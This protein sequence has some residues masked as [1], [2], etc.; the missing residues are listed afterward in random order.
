MPALAAEAFDPSG[1]DAL[2]AADIVI[3]GEHH[4][5]PHHHARQAELI[6]RVQPKAVVW[7]MLT[8]PDALLIT[9]DLIADKAALRAALEWD[10][11]GWPDFDLY[12]PVFHAARDAQHFGAEIPR[13]ALMD[14]YREGASA[15]LPSA[16]RFRLAEPLPESE[17]R[18]REAMQKA[19][20]CDML[21]DDQL[22]AMVEVQRARDASLADASLRALETT[23]G[24]VVVIAGNGHARSDWGVPAA[25]ALVQPALKI[26]ALGQSEDGHILG[27]YD[28][29]ADSPGV[30]REDPCASL[31]TE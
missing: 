6:A 20:H 28:A 7:E 16:A 17:Q 13:A 10:A 1:N 31:R 2:Q 15:V 24:P 12:Y 18:E 5:N 26:F 22:P 3:L 19:A 29:V 11:S 23:G 30:E 21:P 25:L 27:P 8:A 9:G 4:D 14:V